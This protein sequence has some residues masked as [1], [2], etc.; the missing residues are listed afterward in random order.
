MPESLLN[1]GAQKY[2]SGYQDYA[3]AYIYL[4]S[5]KTMFYFARKEST[6]TSGGR[7]WHLCFMRRVRVFGTADVNIAHVYLLY[8]FWIKIKVLL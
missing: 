5:H 6:A 8:W 1:F 4:Y 2:T 3:T 7:W